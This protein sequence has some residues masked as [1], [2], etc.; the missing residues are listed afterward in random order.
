MCGRFVMGMT[1]EEFKRQF[2]EYQISSD[3][4]KPSWNVAPT[5]QIAILLEDH[6]QQG[7][8]RAES[9]RWSLIPP[10]SDTITLRYPTFNARTENIT[11]KAVWKGPLVSRR[12]IIVTN[13]FYEWTG[14]RGSRVPHFIHGPTEILTIAGLYGWWREPE[15]Q[16]SDGWH[17]T[18]TMLT[19][20][21]TGAMQ[22][23]H[24]RMPVF[25]NDALSSDW[26]DHTLRGSQ[27]LV[28]A[29][30]EGSEALAANL[31]EHVVAPLHGNGPEL[32]TSVE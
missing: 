4:P 30:S 1:L 15:S 12:C 14:D 9:A 18:A 3:L 29:V 5:Q 16:G 31:R 22:P 28:D 11:E 26:L 27:Q 17:L 25:M 32:I 6:K 20:T 24:H 19:Q 21:A 13:G 10:W 7:L 2:G 8:L 23:L